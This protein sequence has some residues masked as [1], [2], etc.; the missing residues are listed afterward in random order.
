MQTRLRLSA[1]A[2]AMTV[3]PQAAWACGGFFNTTE[4]MDQEAERIIFRQLDAE[5]VESYIEIRF[6]G[7]P[8]EFAWVVPVP[9]VPTIETFPA[10]A[11]DALDVATEPRFEIPADC[12]LPLRPLGPPDSEVDFSNVLA[13]SIV[14]DYETQVLSATSGKALF[15]HL[16][17]N[18]F[19]VVE[20]MIPFIELYIGQGLNFVAVKLRSDLPVGAGS[21]T[22]LKLTY[23]SERPMIPL[24]LTSMAAVPEMG[25]KVFILG[26]GR[27]TTEGV[28]ELEIDPSELI[29]DRATGRSN[30]ASV[31]ARTIDGS[32]GE[33]MVVDMAGETGPIKVN[34]SGARTSDPADGETAEVIKRIR[35]EQEGQDAVAEL[36]A[37]SPYLTRFYG[38]YSPEEMGLDLFFRPD[39]SWPNVDRSRTLPVAQVLYCHAEEP[40]PEPCD[41]STCG[42]GGTCV[43]QVS[44]G[45][46]S[47]SADGVTLGDVT[48]P[49][50]GIVSSAVRESDSACACVDG[51]VARAVR[52]PDGTGDVRIS[53]VDD[54]IRFDFENVKP[55]YDIQ[56]ISLP[57]L[58]DPCAQN[59]CGENGE[60]VS[61]NGAQSCRCDRGY[62]AIAKE[63]SD[64]DLQAVCVSPK[65]E[66]PASFYQRR[67][68]DPQLPY[69]GK[70]AR[71]SG[72][73]ADNGCTL[74]VPGTQ[75][76]SAALA[77]L[78]LAIPL[79]RRRR[80]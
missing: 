10:A 63:T 18:G 42:Q 21:I 51:A 59:T 56:P 12:T 9:G 53:C 29:W 3:V 30:Y 69:P 50:D 28:P 46:E 44:V 55:I 14:G 24:R 39:A 27:F 23:K 79:L 45:G 78:A 62:V 7:D 25:V 57:P 43:I 15:I 70:I 80:R 17:D 61:M 19:R 49:D 8:R 47:G 33:G 75:S 68:P 36:V 77:L 67:L 54:R 35:A 72:L 65:D 32:L 38:R 20:Q 34:L 74:T 48:A 73:T 31:V 71:S 58:P 40:A 60:C 1:F 66:L 5:T 2:L 37:S 4:P 41:Y 52:D 22:P 16:N 11:F 6:Q 64:G 26:D 76:P 13:S